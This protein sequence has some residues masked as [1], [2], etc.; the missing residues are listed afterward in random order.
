MGRKFLH[1][2]IERDSE[3]MPKAMHWIGDYEVPAIKTKKELDA[4]KLA[5]YERVYGKRTE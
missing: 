1:Y 5:D 4:E 3:G 2:E